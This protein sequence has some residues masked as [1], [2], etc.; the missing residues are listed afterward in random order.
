MQLPSG[1]NENFSTSKVAVM[2][3]PSGSSPRLSCGY[4]EKDSGRAVRGRRFFRFNRGRRPACGR[5]LSVRLESVLC[6]FVVGTFTL[7]RF[8]QA[9]LSGLTRRGGVAARSARRTVALQRLPAL[10]AA[11]QCPERAS[12]ATEHQGARAGL[13][14]P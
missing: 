14:L 4:A 10:A 7:W 3:C 6:C 12:I 8:V 9:V 11:G 5:T 13:C 1:G 2:I